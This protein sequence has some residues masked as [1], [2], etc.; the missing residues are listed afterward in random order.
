MPRFLMK[1][2][3]DRDAYVEWS[4]VVEAP[5]AIGSRAAFV[6]ELGEERLAWTD[7]QGTSAQW[8]E[9]LPPTQQD[10]GWDDRGQIYQQRGFLPRARLADLYDLLDAD[11]NAEVPDEWLEPFEDGER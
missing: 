8:F 7:A 10:G 1:V 6:A 11:P 5:T 9:W 4:T 3:P 2:A